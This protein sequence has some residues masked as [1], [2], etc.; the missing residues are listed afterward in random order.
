MKQIGT[1][2]YDV[3]V[4]FYTTNLDLA[5]AF[6]RATMTIY[7]DPNT[8][9]IFPQGFNDT[10]NLDHKDWGVRPYPMEAVTRFFDSILD[11]NDF[12]ITYP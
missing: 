9:K 4:N 2:S 5:L 6:G 10:W 8:G 7:A 1:H 11:G 12:Y 3:S